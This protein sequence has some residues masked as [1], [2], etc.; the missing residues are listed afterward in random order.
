MKIGTLAA[1]GLIL[2]ATPALAGG[3]DGPAASGI[4]PARLSSI[5][6]ELAS[7]AYQGRTPGTE[8]EKRTLDYLIARFKETGLSPAGE[9]GGWTQSVPLTHTKITG[10]SRFSVD[11]G[12]NSVKLAQAKGI[13]VTTLRPVDRV[14]I[15][16][17]PLVFVGYGITAPER[18]WDDFK[19]IDL[20]GKVA[21]FLVNDPDF[22]AGPAEPVAGKFKGK[23][24]TYYGRWTYKYEE[25]ARRGAIAALIVHDT[26]G[27]GYGWNT[28]VAPGSENYDVARTKDNQPILLQGW[29]EGA[30]ARDIFRRAGYDLEA[31]RIKARSSD[32]KA[33]ALPK[34]SFSADAAVESE[35]VQSYNVLGKIAGSS[36]PD[37]T[38][39]FGAHWDAFGVGA[40]DAERRT[41]RPGALD[42]AVGIAGLVEIA[43]RFAAGP[44]PERSVV[45][46]AWTAEERG[47]L[48][49]ES[50]AL[51]PLFPL[52]TTVANLTMDILQTAGL[53]RNVVL[54]GAGQSTL[55][56][57]LAHA[58]QG[59][60]RVITPET[61]PERGL[62]YRADHFPFA[63]R[64]VPPLLMMG[65][66]GPY[67]LR[68]G[69][70]AAGEKWLEAYMGC[71]HQ[72]CDRWSPD[73]NFQSAAQDVD[74]LYN[75]GHMLANSRA[76]PGWKEG[77]E[78]RALRETSAAKRAK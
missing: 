19:G 47:L 52:E 17:A 40:P 56:D 26:P 3:G 31:L 63:R 35:Q 78:F 24:M 69:G 2:A 34:A 9:N 54:V 71:Y 7:D 42:D 57:D 66:A 61:L 55:E 32:F 29:I 48:G 21:V 43:R 76:W 74:L 10:E 28:V 18:D 30:A 62:F 70:L 59:Q 44:P 27:A 46:A 4:D 1:F 58:A 25:A 23:A 8:S 68:T 14:S 20:R 67:D 75:V 16:H 6:R 12:G 53:A 72:T 37:E 49:S 39:M 36:H 11:I 13:Y 73:L 41:V 38:V 45:F 5:T 22:Q 60:N 64:G 15:D 65:I 51:R 50:Y 33:F 77:S